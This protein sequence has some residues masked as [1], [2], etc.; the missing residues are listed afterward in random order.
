MGRF[1]QI[2]IAPPPGLIRR[3]DTGVPTHHV[4]DGK[5]PADDPRDVLAGLDIVEFGGLGAG[6]LFRPEGRLQVGDLLVRAAVDGPLEHDDAADLGRHDHGAGRLAHHLVMLIGIDDLGDDEVEPPP[7]LVPLLEE[8][9]LPGYG[10]E[11]I[12]KRH[13]LEPLVLD[14]ADQRRQRRLHRRPVEDRIEH[15]DEVG[16]G[17][18]GL[19]VLGLGGVIGIQPQRVVVIGAVGEMPDRVGGDAVIPGLA[20]AHLLAG[21]FLGAGHPFVDLSVNFFRRCHKILLDVPRRWGL[22]SF[23]SRPVPPVRGFRRIAR[24]P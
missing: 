11:R 19:A 3:P 15:R 17:R 2:E 10:G 22:F 4:A 23:R 20:F 13:R 18:Q 1:L 8:F 16:W 7:L 5:G 9:L 24:P 6:A 14:A 21:Q 12:A